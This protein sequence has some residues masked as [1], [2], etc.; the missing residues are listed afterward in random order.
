MPDQLPAFRGTLAIEFLSVAT[1]GESLRL[2]LT[3]RILEE[4][5]PDWRN[6]APVTLSIWLV[7]AALSQTNEAVDLVVGDDGV[8]SVEIERTL[9]VD[10]RPDETRLEAIIQ[11]GTRLCGTVDVEIPVFDEG[12][13]KTPYG[14]TRGV[15]LR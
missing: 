8:G 2:R 7:S 14:A 11:H 12:G 3:H 1:P 15:R 6:Q 4:D 10:I 13:P 9:K 5:M